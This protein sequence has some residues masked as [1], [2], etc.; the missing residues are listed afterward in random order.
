[1]LKLI[2]FSRRFLLKL[3]GIDVKVVRSE[4]NGSVLKEFGHLYDLLI[5]AVDEVNAV[6]SIQVGYQ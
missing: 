5:D 3:S 6:F 1:L 4:Y 2:D